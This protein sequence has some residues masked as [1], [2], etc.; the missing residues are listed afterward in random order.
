[1]AQ[2]EGITERLEVPGE[3]D[4]WIEIRKLSW[5]DLKKAREARQD[6]V[7]G[8]L[9]TMGGD[10]VKSLPGRCR[11]C[12]EEKHDGDCPPPEE[13]KD[14]SAADPTNEYDQETILHA[15]VVSW[16]YEPA[17]TK[18]NR[19]ARINGL[20]EPTGKWLHEQLVARNTTPKGDERKN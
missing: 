16:S 3:P 8:T 10:V 6:N 18:E 9:R 2:T 17:L 15:G 5:H 7:L 14:A 1:M 4:Q 12:G 19:I 20:D 13:R 11:E